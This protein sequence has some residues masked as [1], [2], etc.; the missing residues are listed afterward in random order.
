M[1][2]LLLT[3][4]ILSAGFAH[5]ALAADMPLKAVPRIVEPVSNWTGVYVGGN[6][7]YSWGN[8]GATGAVVSP[9]GS[10]TYNVDGVIGGVQ[11]GFNWQFNRNWLVGIEGD[12]QWSG[13]KDSNSW[14]FPITLGDARSGF[15]IANEYKL[16]WFA[17]A[18]ARLGYLPD[19]NWL[20]YATGGVAVGKVTGNAS[21]SLGA[22]SASV[23]DSTTKTGWTIG[24]GVETKIGGSNWSTK[25]EYLYID[26]GTVNFYS[27]AVSIRARDHVVRLGLNYKF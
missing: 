14:L 17:T 13:E 20:V 3:I 2:R 12:Y 27:N 15:T 24:G 1:R 8:F 16:P 25:L 4:G 19:P 10:Q 7:G 11:A 9:T 23:N 6:V 21:L 18:R 5:T 26:L 22:L